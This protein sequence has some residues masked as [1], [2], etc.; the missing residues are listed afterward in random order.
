MSDIIFI[1]FIVFIALTSCAIGYL[2][3]SFLLMRDEIHIMFIHDDELEGSKN[4]N[5][6]NTIDIVDHA[7]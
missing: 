2:V 6:E 3:S 7:N 5:D 4:V 1:L